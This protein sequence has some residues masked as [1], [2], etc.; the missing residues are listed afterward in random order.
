MNPLHFTRSVRGLNRLRQIATT[1]TQHGFGHIVARVNLTRFVPGWV[2][3]RRGRPLTVDAGASAIGQRLAMVCSDLGPTFIKLGQ[4]LSTRSDLVPAEALVEL[5]KL[6]DDVPPFDTADA[7]T[8]IADELGKPIEACFREIDDAPFATGSIGQVYSAITLGGTEVVVKVRRPGVEQ[9]VRHDLELLEWLATSVESLVP[10]L[11]AYQPSMLIDELGQMLTRELD[12]INEASTTAHFAAAFADD[13]GIVIPKVYWEYTGARV[14]TL[15]KIH[16]GSVDRLLR[17]GK[18][19][20]NHVDR[21]LVARR[22]A[23]SYLKQVLELGI[24]HADP[25]PGNILIASPAEVGLID[26]GQVGTVTEEFISELVILIYACVKG[27]MDLVIDTLVDMGAVG[28]DTNRR[29]LQRSLQM[30]LSKYYGLPIKRIDV[31][32]VLSEFVDV[33]RR[34]DVVIPREMAQ[35][36]KAVSTVATVV[37]QLDPEFNILEPL[38]PRLK[39]AMRE[40][41]SPQRIARAT[42][43]FGWDLVTVASKAPRQVRDLLRSLSAGNWRLHI[44]HENIDRLIEEMDRSSNRLS[45]AVVIAAIIVGSSVVVSAR[46]ELTLFGVEVH[47]LGIA[48]YLVAGVL[49]LWLSWAIFRG[50]KLH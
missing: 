39:R 33:V 22:L 18:V 9:T 37:A 12:Y 15:G 1:L 47:Y 30:L 14:L 2:L 19:D 41:F 44:K 6:Q 10:E 49:G 11:R 35:L 48:G 32:T 24:F 27:E 3:R 21:S 8:V 26:F 31:A 17:G 23:D 29:H 20:G 43:R 5:R 34:H 42:T 4:L 36:I 38:A 28:A 40:R 50:G 46:S 25:H 16:G 7:M 45:F 13:E